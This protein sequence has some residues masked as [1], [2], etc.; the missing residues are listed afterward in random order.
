MTKQTTVKL[1]SSSNRNELEDNI[2][3]FIKNNITGTYGSKILDIKF[4]ETE[5]NYGA[6]MIYEMPIHK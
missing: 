6:L 1:F 4:T 5:E 2:N 3:N